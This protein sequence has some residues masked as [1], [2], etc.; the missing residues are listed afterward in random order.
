MG[1]LGDSFYE[2]LF[3]AYVQS[4]GEDVQAREMFAN[5]MDAVEKHLLKRS[6][7]EGMLFLSEMRYGKN[8]MKMDHLT[9]F[10]G[11]LFGLA[12]NYYP[13]RADK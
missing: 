2:Y 1:A 7:H 9:C 8:E 11:G 6:E 10:A 5:A 12:S 3:K 13:D 4:D